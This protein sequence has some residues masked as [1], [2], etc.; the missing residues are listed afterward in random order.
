MHGVS[1]I[2][3]INGEKSACGIG[4]AAGSGGINRREHQLAASARGISNESVAQ[5]H[6]VMAYQRHQHRRHQAWR[7]SVEKK[8]S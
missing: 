1:G 7:N 3:E 2:S 5:W 4:V 6:G 8:S